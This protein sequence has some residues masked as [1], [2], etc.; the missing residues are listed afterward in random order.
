VPVI[1]LLHEA[2]A[3]NVKAGAHLLAAL[4]AQIP[5][6]SV[7]MA[8]VD[9]G[10]GGKRKPVAVLADGRW[11]VGPDNGL[12][13]VVAAR[14]KRAETYTIGW[15]PG[16]LSSSFHGRDLFAPVAAMLALGDRKTAA[17]R[18]AAL[19]VRLGSHDLPEVIYIDHYG[20]A[21]T[22]L[23]VKG[24]PRRT[25]LTVGR[26]RIERARVFSEVPAGKIFWYENSLGLAEIAAG[27]G[28]AAARLDIAVGTAVQPERG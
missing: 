25:A 17:L 10:V 28:S 24:L 21:M 22:G 12:L 4:A 13:S 20:N 11:F 26:R 1:D 6:G 15:R 9:P 23:R 16:K 5:E 27:S 2:P 7:T 8:V 14:A 19:A 18:K 3:F